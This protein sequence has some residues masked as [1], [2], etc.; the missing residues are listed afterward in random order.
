MTQ[1]D[2]PHC[3]RL[4]AGALRP[5]PPAPLGLALTAFSRHLS[6]RH[7]GLL[8]RLGEYAS[9]K[10]LIDPTDL[11]FVLL[12]APDEGPR[13]TAYRR[14]RAPAADARIAGPLSALIGMIH[15]RYDGDA[16]FFSRDLVVEGD[17]S[18]VLALRNAL[19]DAEL[20]LADALTP[21]GPLGWVVKRGVGLAERLSGLSLHRVDQPLH[22]S[23]TGEGLQ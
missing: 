4:L 12:M 23:M 17:T 9:A 15:G 19:D 16:L 18:A 3:P 14:G 11:P 13:V 20:D 21:S 1:S 2:L 7:D 5:L 6:N 22:A 10:V 8:R